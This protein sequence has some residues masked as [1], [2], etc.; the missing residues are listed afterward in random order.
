ML[1]KKVYL[2]IQ[3]D[4]I[5]FSE[6]DLVLTSGDAFDLGESDHF[7]DVQPWTE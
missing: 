4:V 6:S 1:K 7:K 2:S 5:L 3:V